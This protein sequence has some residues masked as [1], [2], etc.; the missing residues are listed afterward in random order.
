MNNDNI[1]GFRYNFEIYQEASKLRTRSIFLYSWIE[2]VNSNEIVRAVISKPILKFGLEP[3]LPLPIPAESNTYPLVEALANRRSNRDFTAQFCSINDFSGILKYAISEVLKVEF[4]DGV[5]WAFRPYP[6]AGGLFPID[7]YCIVN[8]VETI[9]A[10]IYFYNPK[11][12]SLAKTFLKYD[13]EILINAAPS[14]KK[15]IEDSS[16]IIVLVAVMPRIAFKYSERSYRFAL[17]E[18][19][20]I[21]QN[22]LLC[23][24]SYSIKSFP[25]G[26][27]I[28]DGLNDILNLDGISSSAQYL[29][30][31]GK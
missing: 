24:T 2:F 22:L 17:L 6:S 27:F 30:V 25:A 8:K 5:S 28:D 19:G 20:H 14:A 29:L 31:F 15:Q 21:A 16:F 11:S 12:H 13:Q 3:E 9:A 18:A 7:V 26:A 10:G 4:E 1:S 23:S